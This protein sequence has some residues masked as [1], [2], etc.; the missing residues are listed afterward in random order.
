VTSY[1]VPAI[2][3]VTLA[4]VILWLTIPN[5]IDFLAEMFAGT[6]PWID[7]TLPPLMLALFAGIATLVIACPCALG[8]ATP[9]ALM[10]GSGK[11]AENGILIRKGEAIQALKDIDTIV[12][13]KTGTLTKGEMSL[14]D[15]ACTSGLGTEE[16]LKLASAA[17]YNSEHPIGRAIVEGARENDVETTEPE[18]FHTVSGKGVI[19]T[20]DG[21]RVIVGN[22]GFLEEK[23]IDSSPFEDTL[24][25]WE[26]KGKTS[27]L[28]VKNGKLAGAVAV[29]D[30]L[31][32]NTI[33]TIK[34][35]KERGL[36]TVMITGDNPRTAEAIAEKT[37]IT[38]VLAEV[39]PDDKAH[40][41][42]RLQQEGKRVAMV[43]DGINDAPA[44]TQADVGIAVGTGTDIAIES[45]DIILVRGELSGVVSAIELSRKT[46]AK[47]KQNLWWA[48][49]YNTV[50][51]PLA[52]LGIMHPLFAESAMAMSSVTVVMNANR[53]KGVDIHPQNYLSELKN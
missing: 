27:I 28:V 7:L 20:L 46:F 5:Q 35:I 4:T 38:R 50:M 33:P 22:R 13:D 52:V 32:E 26:R 3:T 31:K 25:E 40:E 16:V 36:E 9:T 30:A 48:F 14:T 19:A 8:L 49:G 39:L 34:K 37:G 47:I 53:L 18:D 45:G 1:F 42:R 15:I 51:I 44:L 43:G 10:V 23:G 17:E 41:I 29:A 2:L 12:F 21:D 11:G 24:E 6:L